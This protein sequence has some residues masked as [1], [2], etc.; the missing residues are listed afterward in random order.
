MCLATYVRVLCEKSCNL[1]TNI[2]FGP[3]DAPGVLQQFSPLKLYIYIHTYI[4]I[5]IDSG[6]PAYFAFSV[7]RYHRS[8]EEMPSFASG[9]VESGRYQ[10]PTSLAHSYK[11]LRLLT[12]YHLGACLLL[13]FKPTH[14]IAFIKKTLLKI[15]N[16]YTC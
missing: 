16:T 11:Y 13:Y 15:I 10:I 5:Y 12:C 6:L 1:Q 3:H 8:R 9:L 14:H 7:N 4:Y 2:F